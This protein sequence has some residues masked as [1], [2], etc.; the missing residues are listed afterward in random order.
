VASFTVSALFAA[1]ALIALWRA[2]APKFWTVFTVCFAAL[3]LGPFVLVAGESTYIPGPWAILRFVPGIGMVRSPSR[4][5]AMASLGAALLIAH[6]FATARLGK[7]R[8]PILAAAGLLMGV[9]VMG[10]PRRM[11]PTVLPHAYQV[12]ADDRCDVVI[13]RVPTGI[14]D[15]T[16]QRGRFSS[17]TQFRQVFHGK[18]LLGGYLSRLSDET[19]DSYEQHPTTRALLDLSEGRVLS[20]EARRR[21]IAFAPEL[22]RQI[23]LGF[24]V[25]N[26]EEASQDL[27]DF[28]H[29]AF[30]LRVLVK[31]WPLTVSI[32]FGEG[33]ENGECG[34]QAGCIHRSWSQATPH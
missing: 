17:R 22:S 6:L 12:V 25:V 13:L 30:G 3:A 2:T 34:H 14:K 32:P 18:R 24:V 31:A 11:F 7:A 29:E 28:M 26:R 10:M 33:C 15:G 27:R 4:F 5:A 16:R 21:A 23:G 8:V 9:E 1:L 20:P 19:L